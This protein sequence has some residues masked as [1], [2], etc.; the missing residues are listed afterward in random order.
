MVADVVYLE[1]GMGD[2]VF[3]GEEV[4]EFAPAGV[5]VFLAADEHVGG[6]GGEARG[7]GPDVQV[8]NLE[9]AFGRGHLPAHFGGVQV[10]GGC[11]QEDVGRVFQEFPGATQDQDPDGD[12]YEG[13]GVAPAG[14][15]DDGRGRNSA[16]RAQGIGEHVAHGAFHVQA[17]AARA[18][19]DDGADHVH[20]EAERGHRQHRRAQDLRRVPEAGVGLDEDPDRDRHQRHAVGEGGED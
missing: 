3:V 1:G 13:V 5:A 20:E 19:E 10:V 2:T 18:V 15:Y 12:A 14:E 4:F 6:E 11:F 7:Y 9:D 17:L 8:V 16:D